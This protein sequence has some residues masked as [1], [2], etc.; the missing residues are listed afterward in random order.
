MPARLRQFSFAPITGGEVMRF[1]QPFD[2]PLATWHRWF[3]WR[4][5]RIRPGD[6]TRGCVVWLE[7]VER[8]RENHPD[9]LIAWW[10]YRF[11]DAPEAP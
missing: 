4:P 10:W 5:V 1:F 11:P 8:K 2:D 6:G 3:A 7:P 9:M